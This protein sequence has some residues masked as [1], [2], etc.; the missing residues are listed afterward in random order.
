MLTAEDIARVCHE[1]NRAY[2]RSLGDNSQSHWESAPDW[3][4]QSAI[5]GVRFRVANPK[6]KD[7]A[8]HENWM[9]EKLADGWTYGEEK[10]PE[11]KTHPC[12]VPY[13]ELPVEQQRKDALFSG[14]VKA[15]TA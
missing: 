9:K 11:K 2:C 15:L 3:Q 14:I 10:N 8:M 13:D 6:A 12:L 1:A 4:K 5:N 7:S